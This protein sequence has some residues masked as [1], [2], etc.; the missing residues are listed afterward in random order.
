MQDF[1]LKALFYRSYTYSDMHISAH[2]P[3]CTTFS[4]M[5]PHPGTPEVFDDWPTAASL[6]TNVTLEC[7]KEINAY[8]YIRSLEGHY[9]DWMKAN[10]LK[11]VDRRRNKF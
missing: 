6:R 4:V 2:I 11:A 3:A 8:M 7:Y 5:T 9:T 1:S 10:L